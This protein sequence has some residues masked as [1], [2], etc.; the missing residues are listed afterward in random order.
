MYSFNRCG[1]QALCITSRCH[2]HLGGVLLGRVPIVPQQHEDPEIQR[3]FTMLNNFNNRLLNPSKSGIQ[4]YFTS[5]TGV[6][7]IIYFHYEGA[8]V[9]ASTVA[10]MEE[11]L[12]NH[13]VERHLFIFFPP[14]GRAAEA[15]GGDSN[16]S[17]RR[18]RVHHSCPAER[19]VLRQT[20]T[21]D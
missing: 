4:I 3:H 18:E 14:S 9:R 17:R 20:F 16:T 8:T 21:Q 2:K 15:A 12:S 19:I 10:V 13:C 7:L 6:S 11:C 5:C 1:Y